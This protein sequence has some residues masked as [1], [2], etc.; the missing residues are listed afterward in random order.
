MK[1]FAV[2]GNP[3]IHSKSPFIHKL[4]AKQTGIKCDYKKY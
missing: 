4:F 3:V 1:K 2:F